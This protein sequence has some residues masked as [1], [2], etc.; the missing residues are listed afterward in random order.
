[1]EKLLLATHNRHKAEEI[2]NLLVASEYQIR[3]L[4]DFPHLPEVVEDEPTLERNALKKARAAYE[5]TNILSLADDTGLECYYLEL[6]PGVYSARYAG[7][8]ATYEDN[9]KKLLWALKA[10]PFR[11]RSARFRTVIAIV[12]K[13]IEEVLEGRVEG[14]ILEAPRGTNGFG[15]DPLF[16]PRGRKK[17]Y[18]EMTL[19]EKNQISHRAMALKKAV[20]ILKTIR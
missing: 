13:G 2:K 3:T 17:T 20:E 12:G 18:A 8:N 7:K 11:R 14:D 1:M 6:Q 15:Y 4:S 10:V 16:V 5:V 9:N 19:E